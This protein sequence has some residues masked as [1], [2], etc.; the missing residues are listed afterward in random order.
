MD[1][2]AVYYLELGNTRDAERVARA[3]ADAYCA[4]GLT[5][6]A[7]VEER[8]GRLA[9]A[10]SLMKAVESRYNDRVP[11]DLFYTRAQRRPGG[12]VYE[13][14]ARRAMQRLFPGGLEPARI[15]DFTRPP[16][17]GVVILDDTPGVRKLGLARNDVIVALDGYRT[18]G[19]HQYQAIRGFRDTGKI[20]LI[21]WSMARGAYVTA[22]DTFRN[23]RFGSALGNL[24]FPLD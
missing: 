4:S 23:R 14:E 24:E 18:R 12:Q 6:L 21:V 11:L 19:L 15:E 3:A 22:Q 10:E 9:E 7:A 17:D 1:W 8:Q 5:L 2:L 13:E 20:E 16:R